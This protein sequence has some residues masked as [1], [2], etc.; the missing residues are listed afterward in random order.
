MPLL[1]LTSISIF[2]GRIYC[3]KGMKSMTT[4]ST[5]AHQ[6]QPQPLHLNTPAEAV[7]PAFLRFDLSAR[8][9]R[10]I[11]VGDMESA[12]ADRLVLFDGVCNLCNGAVQF[13][14]D[15]DRTTRFRFAALQS[16][17]AAKIIEER[18]LTV[19]TDEPDSVM[20]I[21]DGKVYDRSDAALRIARELDG[22][23]PVFYAF[24]VVPRFLRDAVYKFIAR[25][26]Y[27]WFGKTETCR[28]PTPELRARFLT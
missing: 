15:R 2:K 23:W 11:L 24:I 27:A 8:G 13:I 12:P 6:P 9:A 4:K 17:R 1:D 20:L 28:V 10:T 26:R 25:H 3:L 22:I 19:R 16:D 18:G 21:E 14:I 5:K 7:P